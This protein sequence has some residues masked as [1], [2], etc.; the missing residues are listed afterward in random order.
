MNDTLHS[1]Y[2]KD[3]EFDE[4]ELGQRLDTENEHTLTE[5][6]FQENEALILMKEL[7]VRKAVGPDNVSGW[8]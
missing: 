2:T 3:E 1:V 4:T 7:E 5:I 6:E 8:V